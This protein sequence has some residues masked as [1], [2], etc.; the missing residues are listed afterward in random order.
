MSC[1]SEGKKIKNFS[2]L[3]LTNPGIP[4]FYFTTVLSLFIFNC[5][6]HQQIDQMFASWAGGGGGGGARVT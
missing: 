4:V 2:R 6:K 1:L 5:T 3:E